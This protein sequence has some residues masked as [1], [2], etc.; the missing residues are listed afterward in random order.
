M[1]QAFYFGNFQAL[2]MRLDDAPSAR[3]SDMFFFFVFFSALVLFTTGGRRQIFF[4]SVMGSSYRL[5][6]Q[7]DSLCWLPVGVNSF[8]SH[9]KVPSE[10]HSASLIFT[11]IIV[12][13]GCIQY[14]YLQHRATHSSPSL[15][16]YQFACAGHLHCLCL[17]GKRKPRTTLDA[18]PCRHHLREK[19]GKQ[20]WKS[21]WNSVDH[22]CDHIRC[23]THIAQWIGFPTCFISFLLF[24]SCIASSPNLPQLWY[25]LS[26]WFETLK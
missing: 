21:F 19:G 2:R 8:E 14:G 25:W 3:P 23:D 26:A 17:G 1:D 5:P 11:H 20:K 13:G 7:H 16:V 9:C 6:T 24:M 10:T 22:C 12:C 15:D 18:P 4:T